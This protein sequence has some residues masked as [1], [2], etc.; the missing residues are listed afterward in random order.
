M[1]RGP[2]S[3]VPY[4]KP[5][6]NYDNSVYRNGFNDNSV[7]RNGFNDNSVY[8]NGFNDNS[9]Y[10]NGFDDYFS[11]INEPIMLIKDT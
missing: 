4:T 3:P 8:R 7:Y 11:R 6:I 2:R 1:K 9:V 10:R 5:F